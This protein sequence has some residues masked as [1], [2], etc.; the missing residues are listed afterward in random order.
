VAFSEPAILPTSSVP[1]HVS[2][3]P[4]NA[5]VASPAVAAV[6]WPLAASAQTQPKIPRV[7][8]K[9][10]SIC[11]TSCQLSARSK[12]RRARPSLQRGEGLPLLLASLR[13]TTIS[14]ASRNSGNVRGQRSGASNKYGSPLDLLASSG[15][16]SVVWGGAGR[17]AACSHQFRA[18]A[19]RLLGVEGSDPCKI[20]SFARGTE[21]K[22]AWLTDL[23]LPD[24]QNGSCRASK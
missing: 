15:R 23:A 11:S 4:V 12:M 19:K 24:E 3:R 22:F 5:R 9:L 6:G 17:V 7:G 20:G 8:S 1:Q 18:D 14:E 10:L 21:Q 16:G 2:E 13:A